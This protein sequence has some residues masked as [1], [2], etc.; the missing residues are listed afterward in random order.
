MKKIQSMPV[1]LR[2]MVLAPHNF[3][4]FLPWL[5]KGAA[6]LCTCRKECNKYDRAAAQC[7]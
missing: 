6:T 1:W 5:M 3:V 2:K 7:F 4:R